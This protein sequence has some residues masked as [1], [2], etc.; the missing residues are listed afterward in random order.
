MPLARSRSLYCIGRG[1][2]LAIAGEAV[3][4]SKETCR[5]HAGVYSAAEVR[6]GP[7]AI[8]DS[9]LAAPVFGTRRTAG[10]SIETVMAQLQDKGAVILLA[11]Q[12]DPQAALPVPVATHDLL[13]PP[14]QAVAFYRFLERLTCDL[15]FNSD[16]PVGLNKVTR[17][18]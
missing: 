5:I 14:L 11:D 17:M 13:F 7:I 9:H 4:K 3:L 6:H 15:G 12:D 8:A 2:G 10:R 18:M 16:A 1:P